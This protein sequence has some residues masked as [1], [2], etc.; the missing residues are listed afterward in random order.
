M[1]RD[2]P[3]FWAAPLGRRRAPARWAQVCGA[4]VGVGG[5]CGQGCAMQGWRRGG[6]VA[7][8]TQPVQRGRAG[9]DAP[10]GLHPQEARP[11]LAGAGAAVSGAHV[12]G[13]W[14]TAIRIMRSGAHAPVH[15][16][17]CTPGGGR[18]CHV[19]YLGKVVPRGLEPPTLRLTAGAVARWRGTVLL[20]GPFSWAGAA[21]RHAEPRPVARC[22][23]GD[24]AREQ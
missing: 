1:V 7:G 21:H 16:A 9:L 22:G 8:Q 19:A 13:V 24:Q 18:C 11:H 17:P 2:S 6:G 20:F 14:R 5:R 10:L 12:D 23:R 4:V 3:A 15:H